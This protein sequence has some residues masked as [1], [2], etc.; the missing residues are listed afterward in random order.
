MEALGAPPVAPPFAYPRPGNWGQRDSR[1]RGH[2]AGSESEGRRRAVRHGDAAEGQRRRL[3]HA[4]AEAEPEEVDGSSREGSFMLRRDR[5]ANVLHRANA[6]PGRGT[7]SQR[8][9]S[10]RS[11]SDSSRPTPFAGA[12]EM[13]AN[14]HRRPSHRRRAPLV[15]L[16][17]LLSPGGGRAQELNPAPET[18][19]RLTGI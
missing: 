17:L 1:A 8:L 11:P 15:L 14:L 10:G 3:T 12:S 9:R 18:F 6:D 2:G 7:A 5:V 4:L 16:A 13:L 19:L